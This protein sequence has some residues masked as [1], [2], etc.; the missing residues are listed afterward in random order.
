MNWVKILLSCAAAALV[1][2]SCDGGRGKNPAPGGPAARQ[3]TTNAAAA[4]PQ[5]FLVKGVVKKLD[6]DGKTV[7]IKHEEIPGY[8]PA[9]TMPFTARDTNELRDLQAG[10][11]VS[12]QMHVTATDGW[13]QNII[14]TGATNIPAPVTHQ[15]FRQVR[16][17]DPLSVGDKMPNYTFTNE[18]GRIAAF[19]Q[20]KGQ[21]LALTFIFTR[22][23]FPT[24]CPRMSAHFSEACKRMASATNGPTN[25]HFFSIT[26][27][28]EFDT[29]QRLQTYAKGYRYDPAKWNFL[30]AAMIDID[31]I[32]EQFGLEFTYDKGTINHKLRTAV[33]D[34]QGKIRQI[35]YGNEWKVDDLVEEVTKAAR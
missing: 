11:E 35:Y 34:A 20:F 4:A 27:D 13:V 24:F 6:P 21:A 30:T 3:T 31:A 2:A 23:P 1:F 14:K 22:C 7:S 9:M 16:D 17:V 5:I 32:T 18:L 12:F 33:I 25:W 28:P 19:D 26:I 8:M 10:D 29:P 15:S